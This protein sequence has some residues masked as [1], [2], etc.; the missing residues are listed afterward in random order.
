MPDPPD[1]RPNPVPSTVAPPSAPAD[2]AT[3]SEA[4]IRLLALQQVIR[5]RPLMS[6]SDMGLR[7]LHRL[8]FEWVD[9]SLKGALAGRGKE[10]RVTLHADG[11]ASVAD[12]GRGIPVGPHPHFDDLDRL[13]LALTEPHN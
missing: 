2:G 8:V 7:G 3:W 6:L 4:N 13:E 12:D 10:I 5:R 9:D 1:R 11:S